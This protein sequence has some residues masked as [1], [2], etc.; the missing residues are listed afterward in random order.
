MMSFKEEHRA[1]PFHSR[2]GV[3]WL[4]G[5]QATLIVAHQKVVGSGK[6]DE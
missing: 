4:L 5:I 1:V 2:L 6:K 3:A